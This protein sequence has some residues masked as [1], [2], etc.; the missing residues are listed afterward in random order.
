MPTVEEL[1]KQ[2]FDLTEDSSTNIFA[3][4]QKALQLA[5]LAD[6]VSGATGGRKE[7]LS[8]VLGVIRQREQDKTRNKL[9]QIDLLESQLGELRKQKE[10]EQKA[11]ESEQRI[12]TSKASEA[13]SKTLAFG[14]GLDNVLK[15]ATAPTRLMIEQ[16]KGQ[17]L[18]AEAKE[19][20]LDLANKELNVSNELEGIRRLRISAAENPDDAGIQRSLTLALLGHS[21]GKRETVLN[22][23]DAGINEITFLSENPRIQ[24]LDLK[25][26][27]DRKF[28]STY[29]G[30]LVDSDNKGLPEAVKAVRINLLETGQE[31]GLRQVQDPDTGQFKYSKEDQKKWKDVN[32]EKLSDH[33]LLSQLIE[34]GYMN[35]VLEDFID[36]IPDLLGGFS[37][38][39][40][41]DIF[42]TLIKKSNEKSGNTFL[43]KLNKDVL[44]PSQDT[45]ESL[46]NLKVGLMIE[47]MMPR[48]E[49][50]PL[51]PDFLFTG[52]E[53]TRR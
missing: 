18:S 40:P 34:S 45:R 22:E 4:N 7:N 25:D 26:S 53:P 47:K 5:N 38:L 12:K 24:L 16:L 51:P 28:A 33:D 50:G 21:P 11:K 37:G 44:N 49:S 9:F 41:V 13:A 17:K 36:N 29:R 1:Q 32:L 14:R 19:A 8:S 43:N 48:L 2:L 42:M 27:D 3:E 6:I 31:L 15:I 46:R 52:T 39:T 30:I 23:L 10:S 20:E 35:I